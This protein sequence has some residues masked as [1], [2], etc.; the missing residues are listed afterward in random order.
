MYSCQWYSPIATSVW[1][2]ITHR[3]RV[4][5]CW[6]KTVCFAERLS[7]LLVGEVAV[8][9][10]KLVWP[11]ACK[12]TKQRYSSAVFLYILY[13]NNNTATLFERICCFCRVVVFSSLEC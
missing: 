9:V 2:G 11:W 12:T 5:I 13:C 3:V 4:V 10:R 6:A 1:Y 8:A 7:N